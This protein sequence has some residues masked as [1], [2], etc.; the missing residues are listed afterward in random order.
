MKTE[1]LIGTLTL[2]L[3]QQT[4]TAPYLEGYGEDSFCEQPDGSLLFSASDF[5]DSTHSNGLSAVVTGR[6]S[7]I[8]DQK[9]ARRAATIRAEIG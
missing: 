5:S 4:G 3:Q 7:M 9:N 1:R 2:L 6:R 8:G